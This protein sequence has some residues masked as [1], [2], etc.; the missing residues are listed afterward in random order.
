MCAC[1][2]GE[3]AWTADQE[4]SERRMRAEF[5]VAAECVK[6]QEAAQRE[7]REVGLTEPSEPRHGFD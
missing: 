7:A 3:E 6:R 2:Q 4:A 1:E 5:A